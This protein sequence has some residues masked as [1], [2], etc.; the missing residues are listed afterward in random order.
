MIKNPVAK[1]L[2]TPRYKSQV[3]RNK[4]ED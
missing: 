2:R 3:V 1:E 4:K